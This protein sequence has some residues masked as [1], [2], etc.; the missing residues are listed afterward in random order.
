MEIDKGQARI[1]IFTDIIS[2][3]ELKENKICIYIFCK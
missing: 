1:E 3:E 2:W